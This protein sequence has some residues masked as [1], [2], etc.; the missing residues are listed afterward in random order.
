[1]NNLFHILHPAVLI[2][3]TTFCLLLQ[4]IFLP[5]S[6]PLSFFI[7]QLGLTEAL[8]LDRSFSLHDPSKTCICFKFLEDRFIWRLFYPWHFQLFLYHHISNAAV[9][10][11]PVSV[12]HVSDSYTV[13]YKTWNFRK[14]SPT[15]RLVIFEISVRLFFDCFM[16]LFPVQFY[17]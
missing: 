11:S 5:S 10:C 3:Y 1:M 14:F 12:V 2:L 13:T 15:L 4:T 8:I 6:V 7:I 16:L 9:L 17:F